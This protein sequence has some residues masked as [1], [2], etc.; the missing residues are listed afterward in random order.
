VPEFVDLLPEE[1]LSPDKE[2][3]FL[4]WLLFLPVDNMTKK[5]I[6][7]DWCELV[8]VALT[9]EMVDFVTAGRSAETRG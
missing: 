8:G 7:M 2:R 4:M 6:L 5:Y 1:L 9:K 3:E